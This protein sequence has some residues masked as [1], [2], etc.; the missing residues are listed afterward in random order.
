MA[1]GDVPKPYRPALVTLTEDVRE[2]TTELQNGLSSEQRVLTWLQEMTI[3]TLGRLD[4][5]VYSD[6]TRQFRGSQGVLLAALVIPSKRRGKMTGLDEETARQLR[7][8]FLA[9]YVHPAHRDAF[10]RLRGDATEYIDAADDEDAHE[11]TRQQFVAMRPAISELEQ[12]QQ[13][14]LDSLLDGFDE[15]SEVLDWG[16][17][18]LLATHGELDRE[19]ITRVYREESTIEILTGTTET[20]AQARRLFAA[21]YLL[22]TF[23]SGVRVLSGRAKE[24]PDVGQADDTAPPDW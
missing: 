14:A 15:R 7:E 3:R 1:D 23:R 5:R 20:D 4:Q 8:R 12:W 19:W 18:V 17:D 21:H 2:L 24:S 13:R 10:R 11:A 6:M 22:P 16:H 9:H